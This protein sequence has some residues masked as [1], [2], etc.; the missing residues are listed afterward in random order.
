M[1]SVG[2]DS[3]YEAIDIPLTPKEEEAFIYASDSHVKGVLERIRYHNFSLIRRVND[4]QKYISGKGPKPSE[5]LVRFLIPGRNHENPEKLCLEDITEY[6]A[7]FPHG[8]TPRFEELCKA[9][10]SCFSLLRDLG[11]FQRTDHLRK[12]T[13]HFQQFID[14][15]SYRGEPLMLRDE[16]SRQISESRDNFIFERTANAMEIG[17]WLASPDRLKSAAKR[18][19]PLSVRQD[20]IRLRAVSL[21]RGWQRKTSCKTKEA[22]DVVQKALWKEFDECGLKS[23]TNNFK[24]LLYMQKFKSSP[25]ADDDDLKAAHLGMA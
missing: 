3:L 19:I 23:A 11:A 9:S 24:A 22:I 1:G 6:F 10:Q 2:I 7:N 12:A 21:M 13:G 16:F 15:I 14:L 18:E 4:W 20:E 25:P 17:E 5:E 8:A